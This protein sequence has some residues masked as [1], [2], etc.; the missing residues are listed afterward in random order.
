MA[1]M[2]SVITS[3]TA[4]VSTMSTASTSRP[5]P[6]APTN[7]ERFKSSTAATRLTGSSPQSVRSRAGLCVLH[8]RAWLGMLLDRPLRSLGAR[9]PKT[10]KAVLIDY[11]NSV[12]LLLR[13]TRRE[14][15]ARRAFGVLAKEAKC[16]STSSRSA[17]PQRRGPL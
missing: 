15:C 3:V 4:F 16:Q 8:T 12:V 17:T 7:R 13:S 1:T 6:L 10:P 14:T 5:R 2:A 11:V 9:R